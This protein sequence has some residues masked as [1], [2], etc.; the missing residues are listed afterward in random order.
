M[1]TGEGVTEGEGVDSSLSQD[2]GPKE[3]YGH[4][5]PFVP[6]SIG[7]HPVVTRAKLR[8]KRTVFMGLRVK[9]KQV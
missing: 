6:Y 7:P 5:L 8:A 3:R 2:D 9:G 1:G 4:G